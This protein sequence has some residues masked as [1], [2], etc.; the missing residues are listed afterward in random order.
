MCTKKKKKVQKKSKPQKKSTPNSASI[1]RRK[2]TK[3]FSQ[4]VMITV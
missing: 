1:K 4:V 3:V 2:M